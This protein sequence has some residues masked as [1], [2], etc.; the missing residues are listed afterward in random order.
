MIKLRKVVIDV[1]N[2]LPI[3][4]RFIKVTSINSQAKYFQ[5]QALRDHR[6]K[7][8]GQIKD[9]DAYKTAQV[10]ED[11]ASTRSNKSIKKIRRMQI[12]GL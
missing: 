6:C 5:P 12:I 11:K 8:R 1:A 10:P 2:Q 3:N 9:R 7:Y 4:L